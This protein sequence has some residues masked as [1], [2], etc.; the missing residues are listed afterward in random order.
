MGHTEHSAPGAVKL[1]TVRVPED[2][3]PPT[4]LLP[5]SLPETSFLE[6]RGRDSEMVASSGT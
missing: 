6:N 4:W 3:P 1:G 5:L 2:P